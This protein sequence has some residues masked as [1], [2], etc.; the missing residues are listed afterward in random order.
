MSSFIEFVGVDK[1]KIDVI[2]DTQPLTHYN[3]V[4]ELILGIDTRPFCDKDY[5]EGILFEVLLDL[6][7]CFNFLVTNAHFT[8]CPVHNILLF[9]RQW[10][11]HAQ[12]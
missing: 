6:L 1:S 4:K 3:V 7:Y 8:D 12:T 11:N 5:L 2:E 9:I 10:F